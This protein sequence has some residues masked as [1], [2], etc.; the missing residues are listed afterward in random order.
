MPSGSRRRTF[1]TVVRSLRVQPRL[2][3]SAQLRRACG[4]LL[5]LRQG[6]LQATAQLGLDALR[7]EARLEAL[8]ALRF[9]GGIGHVF[10][11]EPLDRVLGAASL[12]QLGEESLVGGA[13]FPGQEVRVA[14]QG[15]HVGRNLVLP[16][17]L[18]DGLVPVSVLRGGLS[19][20]SDEVF[21]GHGRRSGPPLRLRGRPLDPLIAPDLGLR[22]GRDGAL[23]ASAAAADGELDSYNIG[24]LHMAGARRTEPTHPVAADP[25][26]RSFGALIQTM[27]RIAA[28]MDL[29]LDVAPGFRDESFLAGEG[30][31]VL[32]DAPP[33]LR[34]PGPHRRSRPAST[35]MRGAL[36]KSVEKALDAL[37]PIPDDGI[38]EF[39]AEESLEATPVFWWRSSMGILA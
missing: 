26:G 2:R 24:Q 29:L 23:A 38:A 32:R 34:P 16:R 31:T 5:F 21:L 35:R 14:E 33:Q 15:P 39:A 18:L 20:R 8:E 19:G 27:D 28:A 7:Q 13:I 12:R 17:R 10:H 4:S 1:L 3:P 37:W 9:P 11:V 36:V 22:R 25:P 6:V 30:Q